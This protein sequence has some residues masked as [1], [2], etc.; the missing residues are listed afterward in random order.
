MKLCLKY[1]W[2]V[3][4]PDTVYKQD[5]IPYSYHQKYHWN[6]YGRQQCMYQMVLA[7]CRT[8]VHPRPSADGLV[9]QEAVLAASQIQRPP[10]SAATKT[11]KLQSVT[12]SIY[13]V[14]SKFAE[15]LH[16]IMRYSCVNTACWWAD[17][18]KEWSTADYSVSWNQLLMMKTTTNDLSELFCGYWYLNAWC[19]LCLVL[20][21]CSS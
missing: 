19:T 9:Q 11:D 4:F 14:H 15:E 18:N 16:I 20:L 2:F 7:R 21:L 5:K 8:S 6:I 13:A 1:Y 3:F 10:N 17:I 12:H